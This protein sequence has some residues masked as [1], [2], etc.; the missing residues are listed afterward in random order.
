MDWIAIYSQTGSEI[1]QISYELGKNP[2]KIFSDREN[3]KRSK[4][5]QERTTICSKEE[6]ETSILLNKN[7]LITLHGY[8]RIV[9]EDVCKQHSNIYNGHPGLITEYPELK[10]KDPQKK[11][12]QSDKEYSIIGSVIHK[13]IPEVDSGE[14]IISYSVENNCKTE[15]EVFNELRKTSMEC[16]IDFFRKLSLRRLDFNNR[17][18]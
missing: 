11:I 5:V 14:I 13:V 7:K 12:L 15:D 18:V 9:S 16:W 10:G 1:E 8:L 6:I 2:I 4:W 3:S 17:K